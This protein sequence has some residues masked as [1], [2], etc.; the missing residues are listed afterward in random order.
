MVFF[1]IQ[2]VAEGVASTMLPMPT[3]FMFDVSSQR[4]IS[5]FLPL[6]RGA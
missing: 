5:G 3:R 4:G 6:P 2:V 1:R